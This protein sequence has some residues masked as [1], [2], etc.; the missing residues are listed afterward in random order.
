MGRLESTIPAFRADGYLPE[1]LHP[2]TEAEVL[3]RFG[4]PSRRRRKLALRVR[5]WVELARLVCGKRL[6]IDGSFVTAKNDPNDVDALILIP[7][8]FQEQVDKGIESALE[9]RRCF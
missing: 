3:F 9:L 4:A 2:A 1:G 7:T 8:D 5:R 6:L